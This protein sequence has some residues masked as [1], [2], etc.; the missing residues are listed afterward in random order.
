MAA[1]TRGATNVRQLSLI[2]ASARQYRRN[3]HTTCFTRTI[4]PIRAIADFSP[5]LRTRF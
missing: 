2:R 1:I 5:N 3:M 4:Q